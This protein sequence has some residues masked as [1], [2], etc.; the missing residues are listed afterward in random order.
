MYID[1]VTD[2]SSLAG[3]LLRL[4]RVKAGLTQWE[5][6][7][8]A[9][10]AQSLISAYENGRRQPSVPTLTR[11]M[12]AAGFDLRMRLAKPD[13]QSRAAQEWSSSRPAAERR[14]WEREQIEANL[15]SRRRGRLAGSRHSLAECCDERFSDVA[16]PTDV[17]YC[18]CDRAHLAHGSGGIGEDLCFDHLSDELS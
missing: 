8:R 16:D 1:A 12:E 2:R 13:V 14:R 18:R 6:A 4:A 10:V 17:Q 7:E 15:S 3:D 5:L 9:G 11:Q